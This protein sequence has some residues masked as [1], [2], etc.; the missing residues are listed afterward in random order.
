MQPGEGVRGGGAPSTPRQQGGKPPLPAATDPKTLGTWVPGPNRQAV[1]AAVSW[2]GG[3]KL[4]KGLDVKVND[5]VLAMVAGALREYFIEQDALPDGPL[6]TIVPVSTQV[7][8]N[9]HAG[10]QIA[11]TPVSLPTDLADPLERVQAVFESTSAAKTMLKAVRARNIQSIGEVAPP[12]LINLASP[13]IQTQTRLGL[14]QPA[15]TLVGSNLPGP[16]LPLPGSR[17]PI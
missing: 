2:T 9:E 1:V 15:V 5:I 10:N 13:T 8:D 11:T 14:R 6:T 17:R 12:L 16:P 4:R 3:K 7:A